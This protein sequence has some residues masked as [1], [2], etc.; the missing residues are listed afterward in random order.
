[1]TNLEKDAPEDIPKGWT[2]LKIANSDVYI[3]V[4]KIVGFSKSPSNAKVTEVYTIGGEDS[5]WLVYDSVEEIIEKIKKAQAGE[6][7]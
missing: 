1:M 4:L 7:L 5:P 6:N 2:K 3:D